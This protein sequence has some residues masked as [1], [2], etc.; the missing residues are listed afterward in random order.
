MFKPA[1]NPPL[2]AR[3]ALLCA[4]GALSLAACTSGPQELRSLP[5]VAAGPMATYADLV[6]YGEASQLVAV[7]TITD[8]VALSPER[9]PGIA[10]S[11]VRMY[12]EAQT[13][14]LLYSRAPAGEVLTY[15][16]DVP[17]DADG[18]AP[19][20]ENTE[21]IVFANAGRTPGELQLIAPDAQLPATPDLVANVRTLMAELNVADAPPRVSGV[22]DVLSV[23]GNLA[24]ESETQIFFASPQ[25]ATVTATVLRRPGRAPDWGVSWSEIVDQSASAPAPNTLRWYR[26]ACSLPGQLPAGSLL[27]GSAQDGARAQADYAVVINGLGPCLRNRT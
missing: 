10:P 24:D 8:A 23:A 16:V 21:V 19:D 11:L 9:T 4:A 20:I 1:I 6:S 27:S 25:N 15:L 3:T 26:L 17:R 22:R 18:D 13:T 5:P 7:V 2:S 14:R 12:V